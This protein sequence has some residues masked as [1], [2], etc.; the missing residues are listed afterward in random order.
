MLAKAKRDLK[1]GEAIVL[2]DIELFENDEEAL[3][4]SL[5]DYVE[6]HNI[7]AVL[8][9]VREYIKREIDKRV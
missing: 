9:I 8:E 5:S 1:K 3:V 2:A 7:D 4:D 6:S